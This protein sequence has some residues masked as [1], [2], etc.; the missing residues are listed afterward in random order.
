MM[1]ELRHQAIVPRNVSPTL[2]KPSSAT[3]P[4]EPGI[5]LPVMLRVPKSTIISFVWFAAIRSVSVSLCAAVSAGNVTLT[6]YFVEYPKSSNRSV[7]SSASSATMADARLTVLAVLAVYD[8][9]F[10]AIFSTYFKM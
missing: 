6:V 3:Q 2:N 10:N 4:S 8:V 5:S 9:K 1:R 7:P